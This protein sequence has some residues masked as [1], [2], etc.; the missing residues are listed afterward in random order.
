MDKLSSKR[1]QQLITLTGVL[2]FVPF[3][4]G[5]HLFDWDEIN[6]AESAREMLVTGNFRQVMVNFEPF[7]EKPPLFFWLQALSMKV[8]GVNEFA[9]RFPNAIVGIIS[10]QAIYHFGR[11]IIGE[12]TARWWVILYLASIT[13]HFYFHSGI[14][15]PLFNLFIFT[16]IIQLY[17]A[18]NK[19]LTKHWV[20]AGLLLGFAVLTK[21][22]AAGLV[23]LLVLMVMWV[24]NRYRLWFTWYQ[25]LLFGVLTLSMT[26][27]WFLPE[28]ILN[29]PGFIENFIAYQIDLVQNPVA[30]HGQPWFYHPVVLLIGCFPA[31]I[32][33]IRRFTV[34]NEGDSFE[35]LLKTMFWVVLILFS[36]VTTKIVH[37][38]SLCYFPLTGLA[39]IR[40]AQ[41]QKEKRIFAFEKIGLILLSTLWSIIFIAVP[42]AG[43]TR[44]IWLDKFP[45]L[46]SDSFT[47]QN[48]IVVTNWTVFHVM[49]GGVAVGA[50]FTL[51]MGLLQNKRLI[52]AYS[53][54][55][56]GVF[57]VLFLGFTVPQIER[58]TQGSIVSFYNSIA[59]EDCYIDVYKFKS[60]AHY[61]YAKTEPLRADDSLFN[62]R[63]QK[64]IDMGVSSR[65]SLNETQRKEYSQHEMKWFLTGDIDK[66]VYLVAQPRKAQEIAVLP[67][68]EL[69]Q[70][71]GGYWVYRR[72]PEKR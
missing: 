49:I 41:W 17:Y 31:S 28:L 47:I 14:I 27:L 59:E 62:V 30:S 56:F 48:I 21:G 32:L 23:V 69:I 65:I 16:S 64:L 42:V 15:D 35:L 67:G 61:Y 2:F 11:K 9:A 45:N 24:R 55:G 66:P 4:G 34:K 1:F 68:F 71:T 7:W 5:V 18:K 52:T 40:L 38:S 43:L 70:N 19:G 51:L 53:L 50:L 39:A 26:S 29:G 63:G 72:M 8:F 12:I 10:L 57:L 3:L 6:F 22:P 20:Y 13:P 37:Y 46:I 25:V 44:F 54:F 58:H 60:Y 36:L 33:A